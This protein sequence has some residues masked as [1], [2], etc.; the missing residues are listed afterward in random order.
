MALPNSKALGTEE[1]PPSYSRRR[2]QSRLDLF[3]CHFLWWDERHF[4]RSQPVSRATTTSGVK[5]AQHSKGLTL[6]M[7]PGVD[8]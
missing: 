8:A 1:K 5:V 3:P 6:T 7:A 2:S 4:P